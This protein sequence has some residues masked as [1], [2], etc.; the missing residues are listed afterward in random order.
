MQISAKNCKQ[1][2]YKFYQKIA[3]E[4]TN[5]VNI[6]NFTKKAKK[7]ASFVEKNHENILILL[8]CRKRNPTQLVPG[9][10]FSYTPPLFCYNLSEN[11]V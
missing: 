5:Y 1:N 8:K 7:T 11:L 3:K 4:I 2:P 6:S 9:M 10:D